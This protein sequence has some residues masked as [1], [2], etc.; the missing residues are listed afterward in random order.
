MFNKNF[1][2]KVMTINDR[3]RENK[4]KSDFMSKSSHSAALTHV[5]N[6]YYREQVAALYRAVRTAR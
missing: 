1:E 5:F 4:A 6:A 2:Q 3:R